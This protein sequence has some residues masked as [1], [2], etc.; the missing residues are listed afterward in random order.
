MVWYNTI[1][2]CTIG[3]I[4]VR[5]V[6]LSIKRG[7]IEASLSAA[8]ARLNPAGAANPFAALAG[9]GGGAGGMPD[10]GALMNNPMLQQ[11]MGNINIPEMMAN[12]QIQ[13]MYFNDS[14]SLLSF[15]SSIVWRILYLNNQSTIGCNK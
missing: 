2:T 3:G 9:L 14:C 11:M 8:Q 15:A 4:D 12:P 5:T 13:Q 7:N 6:C 1:C 10:L